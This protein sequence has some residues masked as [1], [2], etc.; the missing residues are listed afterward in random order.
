MV[1]SMPVVSW[2]MRRIINTRM[3]IV[4]PLCSLTGR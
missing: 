2:G 3:V 4:S 1:T